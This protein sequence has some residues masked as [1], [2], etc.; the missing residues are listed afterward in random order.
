MSFDNSDHKIAADFDEINICR[1]V[2]RSGDS[3]YYINKKPCRLKDIVDIFSDTGLGRG[4]MSIIG[5]NRID[6]ILNS[7]PEERRALF[8]EAAG[9]AKYPSAQKRK[10]RIDW[11]KQLIILLEFMILSLRSRVG[12]SL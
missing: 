10:Q 3:E 9:I 8:E 4:S 7:R 5:Q 6:E 11:K 2:F 12:L 1:R